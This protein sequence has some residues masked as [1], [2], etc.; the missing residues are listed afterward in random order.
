MKSEM[1][2]IVLKSFTLKEEEKIWGNQTEIHTA[3]PI[4]SLLYDTLRYTKQAENI[5]LEYRRQRKE[6]HPP[7][8]TSAEFLSGWKYTDKLIPVITLVIYYGT[9][10]WTA[11][12]HYTIC[13]QKMLMKKF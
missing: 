7:K 2:Q 8:M 3:M 11:Q 9:E 12:N 1:A 6:G 13:F 4:R 5:A 10:D